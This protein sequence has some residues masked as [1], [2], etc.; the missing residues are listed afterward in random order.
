MNTVLVILFNGDAVAAYPIE[1]EDA[2]QI[3]FIR[4]KV[5]ERMKAEVYVPRGEPLKVQC[6]IVRVDMPVCSPDGFISS[7][8]N[9]IID[10]IS[11]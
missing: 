9:D 8:I 3:G 1:P 5:K 7:V 2:K 6:Q 10:K 4:Q 11:T